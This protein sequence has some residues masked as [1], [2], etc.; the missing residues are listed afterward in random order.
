MSNN[1]NQFDNII[2][3]EPVLQQPSNK[4]SDKERN[5]LRE[6]IGQPPLGAG[7][8]SFTTYMPRASLKKKRKSKKRKNTK[9][10]KYT[11][12]RRK[13]KRRSNRRSKR[14]SKRR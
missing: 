1:L 12:K 6:K 9:K 8:K 5:K 7:D 4:L 14:R 2:K 13:S 11:K 10:R 3:H